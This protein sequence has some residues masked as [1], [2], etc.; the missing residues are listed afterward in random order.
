MSKQ[1]Y[2]QAVATAQ[3]GLTNVPGH[4]HLLDVLRDAEEVMYSCAPYYFRKLTETHPL[5]GTIYAGKC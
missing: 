1:Q 5:P 3:E 4:Q 2:T